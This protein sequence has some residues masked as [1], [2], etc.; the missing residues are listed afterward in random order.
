MISSRL[1]FL[2]INLDLT[3]RELSEKIGISRERYNQYETGRRNPDFETLKIIAIFFNVTTDYLLGK[4][5]D[6][7]NIIKLNEDGDFIELYKEYKKSDLSKE[8]F[9][10]I[11]KFVERMKKKT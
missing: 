8:E 6:D 11:M 2:R 5:N 3:Q 1:R 9:K 7:E 10:E 4:D